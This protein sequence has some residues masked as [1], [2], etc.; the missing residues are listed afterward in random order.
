MSIEYPWYEIVTDQSLQQGDILE[1]FSKLVSVPESGYVVQEIYNLIVITQSSDIAEDKTRYLLLCPIWTREEIERTD[2]M[3]F[4][5]G[6]LGVL[7]D[8]RIVGYYPIKECK[9]LDFERPW[10]VVQFQRVFEIDKQ[11]VMNHVARR[12]HLRLLPPYRE[13]MSQ[14]LARFFM[15]VGLPE[16]LKLS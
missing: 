5:S 6:R 9:L 3:F 15:R 7:E 13:H 16:K 11:A 14:H 1:E 2:L 12:Q 4:A 10:R 8:Y